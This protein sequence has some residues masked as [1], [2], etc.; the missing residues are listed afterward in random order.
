M[1]D[2]NGRSTSPHPMTIA[3]TRISPAIC[4]ILFWFS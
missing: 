2:T 3:P 1:A 4:S